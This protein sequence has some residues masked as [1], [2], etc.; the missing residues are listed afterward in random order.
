M[1]EPARKLEDDTEQPYLRSIVGGNNT[2]PG[3]GDI[4]MIK[5]EHGETDDSTSNITDLAAAR[6]AKGLDTL[7]NSSNASDTN[8]SISE[9]E[10]N[11]SFINNVEG[12]KDESKNKE[13]RFNMPSFLKKKGPLTTI[14]ITLLAGGMGITT[15]L[16]PSML[17]I[18]FK[19]I[20]V[21]KFNVQLTAMDVRSTKILKSKLV[22]NTDVCGSIIKCKFSTLSDSQITK[23]ADAGVTVVS[24]EK[25]FTGRNKVDSLEFNNK[26]ISATDLESELLSDTEF[27]TAV[28]KAY[29]SKFAGWA[30]SFWN[31]TAFTIGVSKKATSLDGTT[32]AEKLQSVEEKTKD[33]AEVSETDV[34]EGESKQDGTT[35]TKEEADTYNAKAEDISSDLTKTADEFEAT[36]TKTFTKVAGDMSDELADI[37]ADVKTAAS[38][39]LSITGWI[40]NAC[41]A[42]S[43]IRA[44]GF[45]AKTVRAVQ[46]ARYAFMIFNIADQIKSGSNVNQSDVEY[47]GSLLSADVASTVVLQNGLKN[48]VYLSATDSFGYKY[49]AYGETGTMP[50]VASQFLAGGGLTG[51]L[52]NLTSE[53]NA[54]FL[55]NPQ[56]VCKID[57]NIFVQMGST[58]VGLALAVPSGGTL[59]AL[60]VSFGALIS[61]AAS[62]GVMFL[63]ALLKDI[64]AGNVIDG[65]IK[66]NV[67]GEAIASGGAELGADAAKSTLS[68]LT[69]AQD[70]KYSALAAQVA[71]QY[72]AEDRLAYSPLDATN[73]NTF[74]G[75]VVK[76]LLP[77][78]SGVS[79]L[80]GALSS[81]ASLA[82]NSLSYLMPATSATTSEYSYCQDEDYANL[83]LAT[84]P[85]CNVKYGIP[86]DDL[87]I[88][89]ITVIDT[90]IANDD[91][92]DNGDIKPNSGYATFMTSCINRTEPIGYTGSDFSV[93]D[94]SKCLITDTTDVN[95]PTYMNKYY[96]L[97]QLDQRVQ[98]GMDGTDEAL[99]A[100]EEVGLDSNI[101]FYDGSNGFS[102]SNIASESIFSKIA[103]FFSNN[104]TAST[105][106]ASN[107]TAGFGTNNLACTLYG[108]SGNCNN[109]NFGFY[110]DQELSL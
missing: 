57:N 24:E 66:G 43:T 45:A 64:V 90:L 92:D 86:V 30:D 28:K 26:T 17:I 60:S 93:E 41:T 33:A 53:I 69:V 6:R 80:S 100:A 79:S 88:E 70:T 16:S 73:T 11:G 81:V 96:Y 109:S 105:T 19:E 40:D 1:A 91:I 78:V 42:Y 47:L 65:S 39:S 77:Y 61:T 25:T 23:L 102:N 83:G 38:S 15:L 71:E 99:A 106:S 36:G 74:M 84:T 68:P 58:L 85:Y 4:H 108:S 37:A 18:Q 59:P 107:I 3:R 34:K 52:I 5:P 21:E 9:R 82:T 55:G 29:N 98:N 10:N 67:A 97:Y 8:K 32:D 44:I 95:D 35:Y 49:A 63:P 62:I 27:R 22:G 94:G 20:M 48:T 72:A 76:N 101:S 2:T 103:K 14:V 46:L 12:Q 75:S 50:S 7:E 51:A 110:K 54:L 31:K 56:T 104:N 13:F 89:P 87:N